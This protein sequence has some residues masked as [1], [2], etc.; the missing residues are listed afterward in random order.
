MLEVLAKKEE[1]VKELQAAV[2]ELKA[3][4]RAKKAAALSRVTPSRMVARE[5]EDVRGGG[6]VASR[7]QPRHVEFG[8]VRA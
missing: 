6:L 7:E 5:R 4:A 3:A 8:S 1:A 2:R